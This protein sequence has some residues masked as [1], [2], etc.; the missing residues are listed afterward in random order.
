LS[1]TPALH[2]L[3]LAAN[4]KQFSVQNFGTCVVHTVNTGIFLHTQ[5]LEFLRI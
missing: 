2:K 3:V 1:V 4:S 5:Y